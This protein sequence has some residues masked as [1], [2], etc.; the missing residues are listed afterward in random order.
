MAKIAKN[1]T[2]GFYITWYLIG[3]V[4]LVFPAWELINLYRRRE[5]GNDTS[6]TMS[7]F[8]TQMAREKSLFYRIFIL[9]FPVFIILVGIWLIPHWQGLCI[10]WSIWCS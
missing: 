2:S 7:Q 4:L 6:L 9:A 10:E 5:Y 8:V 1:W 3:S